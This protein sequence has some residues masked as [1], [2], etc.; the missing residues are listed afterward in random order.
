MDAGDAVFLPIEI[1]VRR[2]GEERIDASGIGAETLD[3]VVW[4]D[5][6]A[7]VLRH[8]GAVFD[9]HALGEE[10]L[11]GLVVF[12]DADIAHDFGPEARVDQVQ[13][14]VFD[15]ADVLIDGEPIGDGFGIE[16]R[17]AVVRVAVAIEIPGRIDEG[18]HGVAFAA[19]GAAAFGA[20]DI[21]ELRDAFE[22]GAAFAGDLDVERKQDGQILFV[23]R[24]DAARLRNKPWGWACPNS[25]GARCPS[26]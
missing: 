1:A 5:N 25:A 14:G 23:N 18:V 26:L 13:N 6:I 19:A 12:D 15:A 21:D 16:G 10:A 7:E 9:D 11:G 8:L 2:G 22:R 3:H 20:L 24:Y 4:G 17:G